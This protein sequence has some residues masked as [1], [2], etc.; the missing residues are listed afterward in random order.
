VEKGNFEI[1]PWPVQ[2]I[3]CPVQ[4]RLQLHHPTTIAY[5]RVIGLPE[6]MPLNAIPARGSH[7]V[8]HPRVG[9]TNPRAVV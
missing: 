9:S 5:V 6:G 8:V 7:A 2:G 1:V 4:Q 3:G